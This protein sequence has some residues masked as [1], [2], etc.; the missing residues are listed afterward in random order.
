MRGES[1]DGL[2]AGFRVRIDEIVERR[3]FLFGG[4]DEVASVGKENAVIVVGA[5]ILQSVQLP[6]FGL[7]AQTASP[8]P[9]PSPD[10]S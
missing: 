1:F 9:Q 4:E 2:A 8:R 5:E 10:L 7:Q 3:T 6:R